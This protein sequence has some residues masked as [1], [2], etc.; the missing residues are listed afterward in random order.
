MN[1]KTFICSQQAKKVKNWNFFVSQN[2]GQSIYIFSLQKIISDQNFGGSF[3][4]IK[5]AKFGWADSF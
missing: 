3:W 5:T 1:K 4:K 2:F